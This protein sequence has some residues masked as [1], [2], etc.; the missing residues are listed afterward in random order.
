MKTFP[1]SSITFS[2][3]SRKG[4]KRL[5]DLLSPALYSYCLKCSHNELAAQ[6][7][8]VK[9]FIELLNQLQRPANVVTSSHCMQRFKLIVNAM[10]T[11][12]YNIEY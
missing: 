10:N 7:L 11:Q 6:Q 2:L 5:Y 9:G 1:N 12:H 4:Q 3:Y 8:L